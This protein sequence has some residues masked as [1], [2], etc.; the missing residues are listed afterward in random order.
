MPNTQSRTP[1]FSGSVDC[2]DARNVSYKTPYPT[3]DKHTI[4]TFVN[5]THIQ[6]TRPRRK[7]VFFKTSL[8]PRKIGACEAWKVTIFLKF[9]SFVEE[10]L[11]EFIG[12]VY[13]SHVVRAVLEVLAGVTVSEK[14][15]RSRASREGRPKMS[16]MEDKNKEEDQQSS[17]RY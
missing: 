17:S 1:N 11:Q 10:N 5:Q 8:S 3:D 16:S 9:C 4:S 13:A 7:T 15:V 14:V 2:S 12:H 6:R